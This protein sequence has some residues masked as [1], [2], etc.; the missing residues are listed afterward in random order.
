MGHWLGSEEPKE[1]GVMEKHPENAAAS[2]SGEHL[3]GEL[4]QVSGGRKT[5]STL[6]ASGDYLGVYCGPSLTI[7]RDGRVRRVDDDCNPTKL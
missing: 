4:E 7:D 2:Q 3:R 1:A 5:R 6:S